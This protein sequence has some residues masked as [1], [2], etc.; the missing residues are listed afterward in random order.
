MKKIRKWVK[1]VIIILV[2]V[3]IALLVKQNKINREIKEKE[4]VGQYIECLQ[5]NFMQRDYCSSKINKD[6][7]IMD[8][9]IKKYGFDYEEKG[10]DL[11]I[12]KVD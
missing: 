2:L 7:R 11:I 5:D 4:M 6:Y 9:L 10:K 12:V 1:V 3:I 8:Q